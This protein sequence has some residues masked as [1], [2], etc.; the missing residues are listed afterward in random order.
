M[1]EEGAPF[2]VQAGKWGTEVGMGAGEPECR[3]VP[4]PPSPPQAFVRPVSVETQQAGERGAGS[5]P[6][7]G[8]LATLSL[9]IS[10]PRPVGWASGCET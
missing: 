8:P 6:T 1:R 9:P 7:M 2:T 3:A 5:P 10:A 4:V